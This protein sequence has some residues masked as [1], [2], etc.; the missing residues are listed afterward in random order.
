MAESTVFDA[1]HDGIES[2]FTITFDYGSNMANTTVY[3][4]SGSQ[5]LGRHV[6]RILLGPTRH[7]RFTSRLC[8]MFET[9]V[10][11]AKAENTVQT[12]IVDMTVPPFSIPAIVGGP[13]RI[14]VTNLLLTDPDWAS[15]M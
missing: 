7:T 11:N 6:S 14:I 5:D 10:E 15:K 9:I 4:C 12:V 3:K 13:T 1:F 2:I 8:T